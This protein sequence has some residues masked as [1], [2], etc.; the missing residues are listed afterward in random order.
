MPQGHY[1]LQSTEIEE[2]HD[3]R[4]RPYY[5]IG[6][7]RRKAVPP[8]ESDLGAV[9]A[10]RIA[11]TPLHMNLTDTAALEKMRQSLGQR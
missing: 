2:R 9:Y 4:G 1:D 8:K 3:V 6:L 7:R 5:W 11:V 10:N